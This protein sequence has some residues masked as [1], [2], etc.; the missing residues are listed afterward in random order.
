M[1]AS[2][3]K[4]AMCGTCGERGDGVPFEGG[5]TYSYACTAE[6]VVMSDGKERVIKKCPD[7]GSVGRSGTILTRGERP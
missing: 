4:Y 5:V 2:S 1:T 6:V 7:L 3:K